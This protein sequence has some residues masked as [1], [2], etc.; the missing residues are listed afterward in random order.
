MNTLL[1]WRQKADLLDSISFAVIMELRKHDKKTADEYMTMLM[2]TRT[3]GG[4]GN[5][6]PK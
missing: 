3:G 6:D 5:S 4:N 1:E 2:Q